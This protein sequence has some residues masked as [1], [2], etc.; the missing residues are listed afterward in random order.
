M[1]KHLLFI[2]LIFLFC[3]PLCLPILQNGYP[4]TDDGIWAVIRL[5][6]MDREI[7]DLQ[8]P[9]R[10]S[11]FLNHGYG[12]PLFL[13]A[14]P[15]PYYLGEVLH[16]AGFSLVTSMKVLFILSIFGAGVAMYTLAQTWWGSWGG[17]IASVSY[18]YLPYRLLNLYTRGSIGE[19]IASVLFPLLFLSSVTLVRK[20]QIK[21]I[22]VVSILLAILIL[23]HN[24]SALLFLPFLLLWWLFLYFESKNKKAVVKGFCLSLLLGFSLSAF[25]WLPAL[26][27][28]QYLALSLV[29]ISD[30]TRHVLSL[31]HFLPNIS[32]YTYNNP[33]AIGIIPL[34]L[35]GSGLYVG[36][37]N[38]RGKNQ[39]N[40]LAFILLITL[41]AL[42]LF[43]SLSLPFWQLPVL[44]EIDFPWRV[45]GV[46][47]FLLSIGIGALGSLPKS[48]HLLLLPMVGLVLAALPFAQVRERLFEP[49]SYYASN[50][51][52]TTSADEFM[53][54]WVEDKPTNRPADKVIT[55]GTVADLTESS[56]RL[57]FTIYTNDRETITI[58]TLYFPGWVAW[59]DDQPAQVS[60]AQKTGLI[61]LFV[62]VGVSKV[63][64]RF[65]RTMIRKIADSISIISLFGSIGLWWY[66]KKQPSFFS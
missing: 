31:L 60:I 3:I 43:S 35:F 62:R 7:R 4:K 47:S 64:L 26:I 29:A 63:E 10:W 17:L 16:L 55:K 23:T 20:R 39:K 25:F 6:E 21:F 30:K 54:I 41:L 1:K 57:N 52:T 12:Y 33:Y 40:L 15:F 51:A 36:I 37:I 2:I 28:K 8:I 19:L 58:N 49:D 24:A 14:Y 32:S 50:D 27:E 38:N 22:F 5:S 59:I 56:N 65:E 48:K 46:V 34:L 11:G 61:E 9:P 13:F 66:L 45:M 44:S 42:F 18:L 53:P